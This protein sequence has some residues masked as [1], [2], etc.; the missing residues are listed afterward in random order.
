VPAE[1][2]GDVA[3]YATPEELL[4]DPRV[5]L[6][7]ICTPTDS[8]V[9]LA[10]AA[11]AAN[12]HV[13]VEKPVALAHADVARLGVAARAA[14]ERGILCMPALCMRFWPGWVELEAA[15]RERSYGA[16]LSFA[17]QRLASPPAWN[18]EFYR[19]AARTGGALADL[20]VHDADFVH[21]LFGMPA[22]VASAGTVDHVTTAYRYAP[23]SGGP[24]HVV[25]E[26][27]WDHTPG[28]AFR[29]R[30][31]AVFERATLDFDFSRDAPLLLCEAGDAR[32]VALARH[33]GY[34]GEVRHLLDAIAGRCALAAT[35][36]DAEAHARLLDAERESLAT[37]EPVRL[38]A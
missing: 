1:E 21:Y 7:S 28:F 33:T 2:G 25:A 18:P 17:A 36:A 22:S 3:G 29:M 26:G 31:V 5:A 4:A 30:Y 15:V 24:R 16:P 20:H 34:D 13:L 27:G 6:V 32:P 35:L 9:D 12:K 19:S 14:A 23:G 8:H 10:L 38:P 11:L 37:G